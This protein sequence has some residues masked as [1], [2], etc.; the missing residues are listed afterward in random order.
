MNGFKTGRLFEPKTKSFNDKVYAVSVPAFRQFYVKPFQSGYLNSFEN[1]WIGVKCP[2]NVKVCKGDS[3]V[4]TSTGT[5]LEF[6]NWT[7]GQPKFTLIKGQRSLPYCVLWILKTGKWYNQSCQLR[8]SF[9][10]E[11]V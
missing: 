8:R 3:W 5:E 11:F 1:T 7:P 9:I 10:C 6:Q 4:Y 2:R